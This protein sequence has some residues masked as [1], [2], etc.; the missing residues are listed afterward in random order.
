[1]MVEDVWGGAASS[2]S[3]HRGPPTV[4]GWML[5]G[6]DSYRARPQLPP[7]EKHQKEGRRIEGEAKREGAEVGR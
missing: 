6:P 3:R 4:R 2:K 7:G 5:P 1:M